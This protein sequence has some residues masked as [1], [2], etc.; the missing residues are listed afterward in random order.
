VV[1]F[2]VFYGNISGSVAGGRWLIGKILKIS[3]SIFTL[4]GMA[5]IHLV[6]VKQSSKYFHTCC[7]YYVKEPSVR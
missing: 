6:I 7:I 2:W 1:R 4:S 3:H 5:L